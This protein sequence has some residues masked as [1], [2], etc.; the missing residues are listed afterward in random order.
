MIRPFEPPVFRTVKPGTIS[1]IH[2]LAG[3]PDPH[4]R[5]PGTIAANVI[6][7]ERGARVFRVHDVAQARQ[8]LKVASATFQRDGA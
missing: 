3:V 2:K 5:V 4:D 6:A 1:F 8:A 7:L